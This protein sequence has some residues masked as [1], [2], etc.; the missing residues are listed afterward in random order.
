MEIYVIF[1]STHRI[2]Y[3]KCH[4]TLP[5]HYGLKGLGPWRAIENEKHSIF[6]K[7]VDAAVCLTMCHLRLRLDGPM[8]TRAIFSPT[9]F[10][11]IGAILQF[12]D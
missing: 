8:L 7:Y 9:Y 5:L 2:R 4:I 12:I 10:L 11:F 1:R 6:K 3:P